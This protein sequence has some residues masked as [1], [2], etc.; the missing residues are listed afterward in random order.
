MGGGRLTK[1]LGKLRKRLLVGRDAKPTLKGIAVATAGLAKMRAHG[2]SPEA[3]DRVG[4]PLVRQ[5]LYWVT[6]ALQRAEDGCGADAKCAKA[7][8][9]AAKQLDVA[10]TVFW[11]GDTAGAARATLKA[12]QLARRAVRRSGEPTQAPAPVAGA[13]PASGCTCDDSPTDGSP[14]GAFL[15]LPR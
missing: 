9:R 2:L 5:A 11:G 10:T 8:A 1:A 14:S 13:G 6:V 7:V 12:W 15:A 4:T 3:A